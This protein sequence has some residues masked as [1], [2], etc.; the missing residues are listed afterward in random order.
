MVGGVVVVGG[1]LAWGEQRWGQ[2]WVSASPSKCRVIIIMLLRGTCTSPSTAK[3]SDSHD[4]EPSSPRKCQHPV[5]ASSDPKRQT[6][7]VPPRTP[8]QNAA[9]PNVSLALLTPV[10]KIGRLITTA[11]KP[12]PGK[13][14]GPRSVM[15]PL[16]TTISA[17]SR[18]W[19][20]HSGRCVQ[21]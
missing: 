6:T 5:V 14:W 18:V 1:V 20:A 7:R 12:S 17:P 21:L 19:P 16:S 3:S 11:S 15:V 8:T 9:H 2:A 13:R 10:M 4:S